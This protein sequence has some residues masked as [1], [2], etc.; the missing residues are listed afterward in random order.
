MHIKQQTDMVS[1]TDMS[2]AEYVPRGQSGV[3]TRLF[4][5]PEN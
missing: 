2:L 3:L 5:A 4:E 1:V